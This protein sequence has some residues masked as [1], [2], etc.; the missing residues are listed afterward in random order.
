MTLFKEISGRDKL[1]ML[2]LILFWFALFAPIYPEM[3]QEW[4]AN[5]DNSHGFI[6]P[7]VAGYFAWDRKNQLNLAAF[8]SSWSGSVVLF[9]ALGFSSNLLTE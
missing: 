9:L 5:S 4:L 8:H 7:F 6:V 1:K 3:V 2:S